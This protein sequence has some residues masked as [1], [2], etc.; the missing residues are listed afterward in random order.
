MAELFGQ[1][2][3]LCIKMSDSG[4]SYG[5]LFIQPR[6]RYRSIAAVYVAHPPAADAASLGRIFFVG[7]ITSTDP[8]NGEILQTIQDELSHSYYNTDD[9]HVEKAFEKALESVNQRIADLVGDYDTDWLNRCNAIAAVI[10]KGV[11]HLSTIGSIHAYL[12]RGNRMTDIIGSTAEGIGSQETINP[13]KAFSNIISGDLEIDDSVIFTTASLLDYFSLEKLRRTVIDRHPSQATSQIQSLLSENEN[14]ST[15]AMTIAHVTAPAAEATPSYTPAIPPAVSPPSYDTPESSMDALLEKQENTGNI[16]TPSLSRYVREQ[17]SSLWHRFAD[18]VRLSLF[19]QSPR[20]VRLERD[21]RVHQA[22][23]PARPEASPRHQESPTVVDMAKKVGAAGSALTRGV[24]SLV[25]HR[26]EIGSAAQHAPSSFRSLFDRIV[27]GFQRLPRV[28]KILVGLAVVVTFALS[29]GIYTTAVSRFDSQQSLEHEQLFSEISQDILKAEAALTYD[30]TD[31]A[32]ELLAEAQT[33][34]NSIDTRDDDEL[35]KIDEL[36]QDINTQLQ[37]TRNIVTLSDPTVV[38]QI[39]EAVP[40]ANPAGLT[41]RN[42]FLYT[43]D[44]ATKQIFEINHTDNTV[45]PTQPEDI[46]HTWLDLAQ[47]ETDLLLLASNNSLDIFDTINDSISN[48]SFALAEDANITDTTVYDGR[49]Y[50]LDIGNS[51]IYRATS[52]GVQFGTPGAWITDDTD[53]SNGVALAIDGYIY[54]LRSDGTMTKMLQGDR[55]DWALAT[56]EPALTSATDLWTSS[57]SDTLYVLDA[58]QQRV[59][60]FTKDGEFLYQYTS[61]SFTDLKDI[62]VDPGAN[63]IY[64]L[65]GTTVYSFQTK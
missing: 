36:Q 52:N 60:T 64:V 15:F 17:G 10:A 26:S 13:L 48:Q 12:I 63:T 31:G 8:H 18:W 47:D 39:A 3:A 28:S 59:V 16:L 42:D 20:R 29:Q 65:N 41:L 56:I 30:N 43:E 57:D 37:E 51:Q 24:S 35:A 14:R 5:K 25:K 45:V 38:G 11:L 1:E 6:D 21:L 58:N 61:P 46:T 33:T 50:L 4:F 34:L 27:T 32:K 49:Y 19:R 54:V 62:V 7:E 23:R 44:T 22:T 9:L 2:I 55:Q 53:V 40:G